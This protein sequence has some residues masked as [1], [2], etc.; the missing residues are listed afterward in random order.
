M[1]RGR[2][3]RYEQAGFV[4]KLG[5][6]CA[7]YELGREYVQRSDL[8]RERER[9]NSASLHSLVHAVEGVDLVEVALQR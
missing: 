9:E 7:S 2:H 6:T 5:V 3:N 8:E 1:H 4:I